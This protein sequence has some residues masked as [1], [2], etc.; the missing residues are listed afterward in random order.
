MNTLQTSTNSSILIW[1]VVLCAV[2]LALLLV[3]LLLIRSTKSP[4]N[5]SKKDFEAIL[6]ASA[7]EAKKVTTEALNQIA[8]RLGQEFEAELSS[9][10]KK[11]LQKF[12][13][14]Q[15]KTLGGAITNYNET[16]I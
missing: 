5:M 4:K 7:T 16:L 10:I 2:F 3:S 9:H 6:A 15:E 1:V 8:E 14:Q 13:E 12:G 11:S